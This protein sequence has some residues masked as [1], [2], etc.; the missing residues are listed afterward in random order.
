MADLFTPF[1]QTYAGFQ[2]SEGTGLGLAISQKFVQLMGGA[3]AVESTLGQGSCFRFEIAVMVAVPVPFEKV[4]PVQR[5]LSLNPGEPSYRILIV[6]DHRENRQ[7][8][9]ELLQPVGFEVR[10]ATNGEEGVDVWE[11]WHPHLILMDIRMPIMDGY[12]A[13]RQIRAREFKQ[14]FGTAPP[15]LEAVAPVGSEADT[16]AAASTKIITITSNAFEEDRIAILSMG[17]NDFISKPFQEEM[18]FTK[19]AE[20]LGVRY[21]YE[22]D[23]HLNPKSQTSLVEDHELISDLLKEMSDD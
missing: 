20:H 6:E 5:V 7:L 9:V 21:I 3:I 23:C 13:I 15:Y 22:N 18:I 14:A 19:L 10:V 4:V 8:L 12:T 17:C 1:V 11:E 2:S 16:N